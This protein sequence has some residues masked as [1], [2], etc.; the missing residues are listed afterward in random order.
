MTSIPVA[1]S[2]F[3]ANNFKNL[4]LKK[5]THFFRFLIAFLKCGWNLEHSE[6]KEEY[7]S[8]IIT[9]GI[10]SEEDIYLS[11][12]KVMLQHSIRESTC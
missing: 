5:K 6:K 7:S 4:Y 3:S 10:A 11:V 12:E 1:I 2:R 9:D 8:L